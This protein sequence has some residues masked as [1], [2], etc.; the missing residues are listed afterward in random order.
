MCLIKQRLTLWIVC[1]EA[2]MILVL[3]FISHRRFTS[4]SSFYNVLS[5]VIRVLVE[6]INLIK[7]NIIL[8][9]FWGL[10]FLGWVAYWFL[11]LLLCRRSVKVYYTVLGI[12]GGRTFVH[13]LIQE[14][15]FCARFSLCFCRFTI[16]FKWYTTNLVDTFFYQ[17]CIN[18]VSIAFIR[19]I[20][21]Q[22]LKPTIDC[23]ISDIVQG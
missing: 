13:L 10:V 1:E 8:P 4:L 12:S 23:L 18:L 5:L 7:S 3:F 6:F 17:R 19:W 2:L 9:S 21:L 22:W 11:H 20:R 15:I 16:T 14:W